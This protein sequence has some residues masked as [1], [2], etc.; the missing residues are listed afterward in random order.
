LLSILLILF[1]GGA[2]SG[3]FE[4]R[5]RALSHL[6]VF[7]LF[8]LGAP[9]APVTPKLF[10]N[11]FAQGAPGTPKFFFNFFALKNDPTFFSIFLH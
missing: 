8:K 3:L 6:N 4:A 11:Y 7:N 5:W 1:F 9:G 2:G 10:F